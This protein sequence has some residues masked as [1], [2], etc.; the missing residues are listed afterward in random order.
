MVLNKWSQVGIYQFLN[1]LLVIFQQP[2]VLS[3]YKKRQSNHKP[4]LMMTTLSDPLNGPYYQEFLGKLSNKEIEKQLCRIFNT[5]YYLLIHRIKRD[6]KY[7]FEEGK[8]LK[9][10]EYPL[11][12]S[13]LNIL[14]QLLSY[15]VAKED[16]LYKHLHGD[17]FWD[18]LFYKAFREEKDEEVEEQNTR[19]QVKQ[20]HAKPLLGVDITEYFAQLLDA[21]FREFAQKSP[22]INVD[23]ELLNVDEEQRPTNI[24]FFIR[25]YE[26]SRTR[27][28]GHYDFTTRMII[29][30]KQR[31]QFI[32]ALKAIVPTLENPSKKW[33]F[34]GEGKSL[35]HFKDPNYI[36]LLREY[37]ARN[38]EAAVIQL[39]QE[40]YGEYARSFVDSVLHSGFLD[41]R[42]K[43]L[44]DKYGL[45]RIEEAIEIEQ[46][47]TDTDKIRMVALFYLFSVMKPDLPGI[48]D[49][50]RVS[51]LIK[52]LRIS[53][54]PFLCMVTFSEFRDEH[55]EN[56][57]NWQLY[58]HFYHDI[59]IPMGRQ[60]R[61][62]I[63]SE[64]LNFVTW[65]VQRGLDEV[66]WEYEQCNGEQPFDVYRAASIMNIHLYA[67]SK[68]MPFH[69][70]DIEAVLYKDDNSP[71]YIE[72]G[73]DPCFF[74]KFSLRANPHYPALMKSE[75]FNKSPDIKAAIQQ[76]T[77]LFYRYIR[78]GSGN[79]TTH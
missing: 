56:Y 49:K 14:K 10:P 65:I 58:H 18:E 21:P 29:P 57:L 27:F 2:T 35:E 6:E 71:F 4:K 61:H 70:I 15:S 32:A 12:D 73:G 13:C 3:I 7:I 74:L 67:L 76:G 62:L 23:E 69:L 28:Y 64:Y 40:P 8:A 33:R 42:R 26:E 72:L 79:A 38:D 25:T 20:P 31:E 52:P 41:I 22:L 1:R 59:G 17:D 48:K 60:I 11:D 5:H 19:N 24:C 34:R 78:T 51:C 53:A 43:P 30:Q 54:S 66:Q 16:K 68:V 47:T 63:R 46:E 36:A 75:V 39:L 44:K 37:V 77:L 9:F 50:H 45:D 55:Q